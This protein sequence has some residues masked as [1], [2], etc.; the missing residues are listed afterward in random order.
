MVGKRETGI[1]K[2]QSL[3]EEREYWEARGSLAEGHKG[4]VNRP[5]SGQKRSSFLA[6]RLTGEELTRLRDMAVR[7][8]LG[9]STFAR[10][11]LLSAI[12]SQNQTKA[13]TLDQLIGLFEGILPNEVKEKGRTLFKNVALGDPNNPSMLI[14]DGKQ[15]KEFEKFTVL[16]LKTILASMGI[17]LIVPESKTY[18]KVREL[19]TEN[20]S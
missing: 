14:V 15:Q 9:P 3:E 4:R 19:V 16:C 17:R 10:L 13:V 20:P 5:K 18:E 11:V 2:F 6:V 1:P 8:G 12:E 7:Q